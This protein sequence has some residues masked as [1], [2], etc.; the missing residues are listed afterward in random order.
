[1]SHTVAVSAG[2]KCGLGDMWSRNTHEKRESRDQLQL[3]ENPNCCQPS[4]PVCAPPP[5]PPPHTP[6]PHSTHTPSP[7]CVSGAHAAVTCQLPQ[8]L[9]V[10]TAINTHP[11]SQ[12]P[13]ALARTLCAQC[14]GR[15]GGQSLGGCGWS[16]GGI[17]VWGVVAWSVLSKACTCT[18]SPSALQPLH[19]PRMQ[20]SKKDSFKVA[21]KAS[22]WSGHPVGGHTRFL[23]YTNSKSTCTLDTCVPVL[24]FLAQGWERG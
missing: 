2:V 15:G 4:R 7:C 5:T 20:A 9:Q 11:V 1:M 12:R 8:V 10:Y 24:Q 18:Q 23:G 6:H 13:P 14:V 22:G 3:L 19:A 17:R 21:V 16:V